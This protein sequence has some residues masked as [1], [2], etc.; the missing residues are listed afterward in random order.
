L[1][2]HLAKAKEGTTNS[3]YRGA[4]FRL[5]SIIQSRLQTVSEKLFA[6]SEVINLRKKIVARPSDELAIARPERQAKVKI[7]FNDST[8]L[9]HH[10]KAVRGTP[11][12]PMNE[13]EIS[14][15]AKELLKSFHS[16]QVN[17]LIDLVLNKE[18]VVEEL[19]LT[20]DF[21]I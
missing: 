12:N 21:K 19:I 2:S 14:Y 13:E 10:A 20:L 1:P 8:E 6:D 4:T 11:D 9:S 5:L 15:K 16:S 17:Q 7:I 3:I 18:F